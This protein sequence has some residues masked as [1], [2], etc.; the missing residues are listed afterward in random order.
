[1]DKYFQYIFS[2]R[3]ADGA[4]FPLVPHFRRALVTTRYVHKSIMHKG[5]I[6]RLCQ[7]NNAHTIQWIGVV[8]ILHG[9]RCRLLGNLRRAHNQ[10]VIIAVRGNIGQGEFSF[11]WLLC[12]GDGGGNS[13]SGLTYFAGQIF[14]C[15]LMWM[16][17]HWRQGWCKIAG[18]KTAAYFN[19][20]RKHRIRINIIWCGWRWLC[21]RLL[22]QLRR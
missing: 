16:G 9:R 11:F 3:I 10:I 7:T 1:M 2:L 8:H 20:S 21:G 15:I 17:N 12:L 19:R 22:R 13:I 6:F 14:E 4:S 18:W 5:S